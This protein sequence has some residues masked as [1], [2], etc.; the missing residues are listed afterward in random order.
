LEN[1]RKNLGVNL[2][3]LDMTPKAQATKSKNKQVALHQTEKHLHSR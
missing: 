1:H 2:G 3:N